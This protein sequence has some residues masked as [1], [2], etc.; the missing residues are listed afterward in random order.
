MPWTVANHDDFDP[1]F[2]ALPVAVLAQR[3]FRKITHPFTLSLREG[4]NCRERKRTEIS[5]R[6]TSR[7]RYPSPEKSSELAFAPY[8]F[9]ATVAAALR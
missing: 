3:T 2:D 4:R 6:G 1:E 8:E 7:P 5:G 9:V